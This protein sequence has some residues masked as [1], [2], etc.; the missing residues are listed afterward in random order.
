MLK[1]AFLQNI[2]DFEQCIQIFSRIG[3]RLN[4]NLFGKPYELIQWMY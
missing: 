1:M 4:N 2:A 3:L